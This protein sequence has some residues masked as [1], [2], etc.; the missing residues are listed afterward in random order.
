[1]SRRVASHVFPFLFVFFAFS[2]QPVPLDARADDSGSFHWKAVDGAQ[3]K[4]DDKVPL[5][6]NVFQ[7]E[8]KKD[9][10]L[11]L[12]LLGRRYILLDDKA[13]L[14]YL[15]MPTDL[16]GS[17]DDF[18]SGNLVDPSRLIPSTD[19]SV[20]DVGPA[21]EIRCT[22]EDYGRDLS[23]QLPHPIDIRLGIY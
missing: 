21:E 5:A 18:D 15:V 14:A 11:A 10:N 2:L 4:L 20:R 3:V 16:H 23:V 22:L 6:W 12:V 9:Q 19:W 8:K 7:L 1:M 13:K 17:G